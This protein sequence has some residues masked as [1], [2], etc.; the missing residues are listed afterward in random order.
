MSRSLKVESLDSRKL[1]LAISPGASSLSFEDAVLPHIDSAYKLAHWLTK[2]EADAQDVVQEAYL[3]A[4]KFF[5]SFHGS[6]SRP[7]LLTIVR[8]TCYTW[9]KRNR[10]TEAAELDEAIHLEA[11]EALDPEEIVI[12]NSEKMAVREALETLPLE[13]REILIMRELEELSYREI[14]AMVAIPVGTVMS[15]L[16]RARQKLQALMVT[17][18]PVPSSSLDLHCGP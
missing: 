17:P 8:N 11:T 1:S 4:L 3:R 13:F 15:R 6:D 9:L 14:A 2:N 12:L 16:A 5:N 10:P 7:W 18:T